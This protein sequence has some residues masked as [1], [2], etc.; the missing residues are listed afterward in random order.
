MSFG[1]VTLAYDVKVEKLEGRSGFCSWSRQQRHLNTH[2]VV[3]CEVISGWNS[4]CLT[5]L[6][7]LFLLHSCSQS[8]LLL[9][10]SAHHAV[11]LHL[12][13]SLSSDHLKNE[14]NYLVFQL[15]FSSPSIFMPSAP[16]FHRPFYLFSPPSAPFLP[17]FL[18]PPASLVT[19]PLLHFTAPQ[20]SS[21][22]RALYKHRA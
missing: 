17:T 19:W 10:S 1:F 20:R 5:R 9:S 16:A 6:S 3:R 18:L 7:S 14:K 11:M 13:T 12:L 4:V 2:S 22:S 8:Y 21:V 15:H